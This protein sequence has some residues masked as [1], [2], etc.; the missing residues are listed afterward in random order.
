[1]G[2]EAMEHRL[3]MT[4][5]SIKELETK[6]EEFVEGKSGIEGLYQ[7]EVKRN[8]ETLAAIG[9]DEEMGEAV[10]KWIQRGKW[11]R[12][13]EL[14]VKG[15]PIEW[16]QL[17][18]ATKPRRVSLPTYPFAKEH[19][20][21]D[22]VAGGN[23]A[24]VVVVTQAA[25]AVFHPLLHLNIS[26][27]SGQR[28]RSTF[29]GE[30]FFL[31]DHRLRIDGHTVQKVMPGVAYLEMA[32]AAL[33]QAS[34]DQTQA[35]ILELHNTIWLRPLV[36]TEPREVFIALSVNDDEQVDF[37]I[38][39]E[40]TEQE[41][42]YCEGQ[43]VFGHRSS[44]VVLDLASLRSQMGRGTLEGA[45]IYAMYSKMGITYG[46]GHQGIITIDLGEKQL[47]AQLRLPSVI[48]T[49]QYEYVL[50][51]SLMDSA[52]QASIG[53]IADGSLLPRKPSVPFALDSLRILSACTNEMVAWI[54]YSAVRTAD[55]HAI[56]L[57][58]DL[59]DVQGNV[60]VQMRGLTSRVIEHEVEASHRNAVPA[61]TLT[62]FKNDGG[63][64]DSDFYE[65][66]IAD[67]VNLNVSIDD[68]VTFG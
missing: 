56:T 39:S 68:A 51:P 59:C 12:L 7:G 61:F 52:L 48:S 1:V 2:R 35:S 29:T 62:S 5:G 11:S 20:W 13:L 24:S 18:G 30:E 36:V 67:I 50:H 57:D 15:F 66:L 17:Y 25:T 38:Y 16:E 8:D 28:Y 65:K 23:V 49:S 45:D 58:I 21:I 27:L 14:W 3:G 6:L 63:A 32:R 60:C 54:R 31:A 37:K 47:L 33:E 53:L 43:A 55:D 19:Y 4:I 41:T 40:E 34:P 9:G 64:F 46:P 44:P 22:T 26:D 42:I 10:S